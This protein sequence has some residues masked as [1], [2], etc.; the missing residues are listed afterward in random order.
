MLKAGALLYAI[1]ISF[2]IST[3]SAFLILSAFHI[4]R[5]I[6]N[7]IMFE[8]MKANVHS[9][10]TYFLTEPNILSI[11]QEK[12]IDLFDNID[13]KTTL[14]HSNWGMYSYISSSSKWKHLSYSKKALL[15]DHI[16]SKENV[17]LYLA[18][19]NNYISLCGKTIIKGSAFLP[20]LGPK[21]AYIEGKSFSGTKLIEGIIKQS[22]KELPSINQQ[23]IAKNTSYLD[24]Q[25]QAKDSLLDYSIF[26]EMDS[27]INSFSNKTVL[28]QF[29]E[30]T[31]LSKKTI[32]GNVILSSRYPIIVSSDNYLEDLLIYASE[33]TL[34]SRFEGKV[35]LIA[36]QKIEVNNNVHLAY[37]SSIVLIKNNQNLNSNIL[38]NENVKI[39][40]SLIL[41]N[42]KKDIKNRALLS[43]QKNS[44][45]HGQVYCNDL[46]EH[47]GLIQGCLY[48]NQFI[49]KT[50]SSVY[51]NHLL[52]ATIDISQLSPFFVGVNLFKGENKKE[53]IKWME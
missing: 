50:A 37:P 6:E 8:Q 4:N 33:I 53:I 18:D 51:E 38:I 3:I 5:H 11:G 14:K 36:S 45:I 13:T 16:L 52:D 15:G 42:L 9:A 21:R 35:Q 22:E 29:P 41:I 40:G 44:K 19:Q 23:L 12:E 46:T 43:I 28:I 32:I 26:L 24:G 20:K 31:A 48:A 25:T 34:E 7:T 10:I 30:A 39:E 1:F 49:L 47:R 17:V 27:I 2:L